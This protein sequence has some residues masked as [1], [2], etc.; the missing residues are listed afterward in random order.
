MGAKIG[1]IFSR[2]TSRFSQK[3]VCVNLRDLR[4]NYFPLDAFDFQKVVSLPR[5]S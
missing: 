2:K 3:K 1:K 5:N 4:D